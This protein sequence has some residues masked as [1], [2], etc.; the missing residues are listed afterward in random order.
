VLIPIAKLP[1]RA[2]ALSRVRGDFISA[3]VLVKKFRN[4]GL[5]SYS[6]KSH[7]VV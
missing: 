5:I 7:H 3:T 2:T 6:I 4:L 1:A